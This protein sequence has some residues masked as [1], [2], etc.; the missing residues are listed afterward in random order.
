MSLAG[1][2][3]AT[4]SPDIGID[5]GTANTVVYAHDQGVLVSEPSVVAYRT[6]DDAIVA[7]G[8]EAKELDGRAHGT[9]SKP[10]NAIEPT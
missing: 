4:F 3:R 1:T 8:R 6:S 7:I 9:P 5:L 10:S 2:L